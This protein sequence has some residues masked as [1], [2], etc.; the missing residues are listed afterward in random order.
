M[1]LCI[2]AA[3]TNGRMK[4]GNV[5]NIEGECNG[6]LNKV[7]ADSVLKNMQKRVWKSYVRK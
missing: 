7:F 3:D 1:A 5:K 2:K 6:W 4:C